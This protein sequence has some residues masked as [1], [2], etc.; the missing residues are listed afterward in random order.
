MGSAR[1][2]AGLSQ[3]AHP[4][5]CAVRAG[6]GDRHGGA[7]HRVG[8]V[9]PHRPERGRREQAG[10]RRPDRRPGGGHGG[11]RRLHDLR[12]DADDAGDQP[13]RLQV[14]ALRPGEELRTDQRPVERRADRHGA[15]R[16]AGEVDRRSHRARP[17]A[18]RQADVRQR[19][20]LGPRRRRA[21]QDHGQGR[22]AG[23]AL[24]DPAAGHRRPAGRPHR[25]HLQ[26]LHDRPAAGA[27]R[28]SARHRGDQPAA[29]SRAR[30]IPD[31][32]R[33]RRA[34]LRVA[35]LERRLCA[36]RH[37]AADHRQAEPAD[38]RGGGVRRPIRT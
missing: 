12:H 30:A 14:A 32:R 17:R 35:A 26:R 27:R 22:P 38:P 1:R 9:A 11:A 21:V 36:G 7:R 25:R 16:P 19:Q 24:Q 34:R 33:E 6:N 3:Q 20:R 13:A 2:R 4:D 15:Q 29:L 18:A 31:R 28:S 8:I 10:R 23:R 37:A 5:H